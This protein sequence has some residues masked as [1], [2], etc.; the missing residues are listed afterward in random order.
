MKN[1][2]TFF[3]FFWLLLHINELR[4]DL[5]KGKSWAFK[6]RKE[7]FSVYTL[8]LEKLCYSLFHIC[9]SFLHYCNFLSVIAIKLP[10][11]W[12]ERLIQKKELKRSEIQLRSDTVG[13]WLWSIERM[14]LLLTQRRN[15]DG[16]YQFER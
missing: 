8:Y 15:Y 11:S 12:F 1:M 13:Y 3:N 4:W 9:L 5:C 2:S 7:L 14:N 6:L 16:Y 10:F